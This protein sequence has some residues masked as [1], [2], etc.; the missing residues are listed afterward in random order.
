MFAVADVLAVFDAHDGCA[1][2]LSVSF[3]F[4]EILSSDLCPEDLGSMENF[5][6]MGSVDLYFVGD[7][8][9]VDDGGVVAVP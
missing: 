6:F 5:E 4:G 3:A 8:G 2:D 9:A 1:Y 7:V